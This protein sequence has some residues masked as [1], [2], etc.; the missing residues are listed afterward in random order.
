MNVCN[1][2]TIE[3]NQICI[4]GDLLH[5]A[6]LSRFGPAACLVPMGR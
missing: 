6:F 1:A 3:V 5:A 4:G 2:K